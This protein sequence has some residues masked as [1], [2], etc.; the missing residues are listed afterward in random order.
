MDL[1]HKHWAVIAIGVLIGAF[2][3]LLAYYLLGSQ[4]V[5]APGGET[6]STAPQTGNSLTSSTAPA[7][8]I[9]EHAKYYDI[10]MTYPSAT[11]LLSVSATA[12]A[13]AVSVMRA[14][15]QQ[16]VEQFKKDGN[17]TNLTPEDVKIMRLDERQE[18]LSSEYKVYTGPRTVSYSF[19]IYSDTLGAHP[20]S[21][22]QTFTFDT[23]T[24]AQLSL[25]DLFLPSVSYLEKMSVRARADLPDIIS[26]MSEGT[27]GDTDSIKLGTAP[28]KDNFSTF[29]VEGKNL[30]LVF[31]PYQVGP[32]ALGTVLYPIPLAQLSDSLKTEYR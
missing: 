10:D 24:G 32:Y 12:N 25:S 16:V 3:V 28:T 29:Y 13:Q 21:Y 9:T 6:T 26:K 17:F 11:P 22:Y 30:V 14:A 2:G 1:K 20:N 4:K 5:L 8:H 31:P 19:L 15:M 18:A 23:Q 27:F 7:L